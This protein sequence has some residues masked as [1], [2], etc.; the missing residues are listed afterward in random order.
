LAI[1]GVVSKARNARAEVGGKDGLAVAG[2]I[3]EAGE[4]AV[5]V[6]IEAVAE[7]EEAGVA[8]QGEFPKL[9]EAFIEREAVEKG[10]E[11]VFRPVEEAPLAE[12]ALPG[13]NFASAP[14]VFQIPSARVAEG[15][16]D[17]KADVLDG[18]GAVE[19]A[20]DEVARSQARRRGQG[21]G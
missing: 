12:E 7:Y 10:K 15:G 2:G 11:A 21:F 1:L 14:L 8:G 6:K 9:A 20:G 17:G 3:A 5:E 4:H 18:D 13:V 19:I 16:D